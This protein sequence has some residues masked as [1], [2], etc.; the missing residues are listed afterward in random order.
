MIH[1][2]EDEVIDFSHGLAIHDKCPKAVEPLWVEVFTIC[3]FIFMMTHYLKIIL[4]GRWSQWRW[5]VQPIFGPS[6]TVCICRIGQ[7]TG[8]FGH[9]WEQCQHHLQHVHRRLSLPGTRTSHPKK[10]INEPNRKTSLNMKET[11]EGISNN[12]LWSPQN[13]SL[14]HDTL[15]GKFFFY[16]FFF[17]FSKKS[18]F[19]IFLEIDL[20]F[21]LTKKRTCDR[22][23]RWSHTFICS[24]V[25]QSG[26]DVE[27][28]LCG[29]VRVFAVD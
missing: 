15:T 13:W 5:I 1:G 10:G 20:L 7:L 29:C 11:W 25:G 23:Y 27:R 18:L 9:R 12:T 26:A 22:S 24:S 8:V 28:I 4:K 16:V 14:T 19:A 21:P 2:T 3:L 17:F 6:E